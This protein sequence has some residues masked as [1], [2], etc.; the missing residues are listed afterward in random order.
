VALD[1]PIVLDHLAMPQ[2]PEDPGFDAVLG[3]LR[4][5][6]V[7]VKATLC[8]VPGAG[9]ATLRP[10]QERRKSSWTSPRPAQRSRPMN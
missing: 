2:G 7:W 6:R 5:G 1:V 9:P 3:H 10:L 8:R 4:G